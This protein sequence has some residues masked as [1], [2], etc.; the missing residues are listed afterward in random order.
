MVDSILPIASGIGY[1]ASFPLMSSRK[2][3]SNLIR[4]SV[5]LVAPIDQTQ[6]KTVAHLAKNRL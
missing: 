1:S 5:S 3:A 4:L 2:K 6:A